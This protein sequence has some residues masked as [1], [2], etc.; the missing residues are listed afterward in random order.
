MTCDA[1]RCLC[2]IVEL[3]SF[4]AAAERLHRSQPAI[5]QQ[6]KS[7]EREVGHSLIER[8]TCRP[9]PMGA[10]IY[11]QGTEILQAVENL[12][13]EVADF[14][15]VASRELRVGTSDTTALYVLPPLAREFSERMPET[16]L[17]LV[18]RSSGAIVEQVLDGTLD[19]GIVTLPTEHP[20]LEETSLFRQR[21]VV[22]VPERHALAGRSRVSL[23]TLAA[24][25]FVLL[26]E[27]TRTGVLLRRYFAEYN[28]TPQVV[29]DSG[30]FEVIK[31]FVAEGVGIS[32]LPE[33][34]VRPDDHAL[35]S[36][37]MTGL[38]EVT[39]GAIWR[40]G[41]YQSKAQRAF[42]AMLQERAER[43]R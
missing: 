24:E 38:P 2:A 19:L 40:R 4:R 7:L 28:F 39:L 35:R 42:V 13:H 15:S 32:L 31:R 21:F 34:V 43:N 6:L 3:R 30:S 9:T 14:E 36:I 17:V 33:M 11:A 29:V 16:R 22:V 25:S 23:E 10:L 5:S 1:L 12:S 20:E 37:P 18:N 41:A 8:K 26:E 27:A